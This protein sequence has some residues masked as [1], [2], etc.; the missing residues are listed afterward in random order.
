[1]TSLSEEKTLLNIGTEKEIEG[2]CVLS[3]PGACLFYKNKVMEVGKT[4][5]AF[6]EGIRN[7]P[8]GW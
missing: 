7:K 1:M 2:A 3:L 4:S 6:L 8:S 5:Q